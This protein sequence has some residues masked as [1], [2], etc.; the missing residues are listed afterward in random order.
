MTS[1]RTILAR[2]NSLYRRESGISVRTIRPAT[3]RH[4]RATAAAFATDRSNTGLHQLDGIILIRQI[5]GHAHCDS[6]PA[7]IDRYQRG[8]TAGHFLLGFIN[9][10]AQFL[11]I[12][13]VYNLPTK[14]NIADRFHYRFGRAAAFAG[15]RQ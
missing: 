12:E 14:L 6:G 3:L 1:C 15:Q 7:I 9:Q 4:V 10:S 5:I 8:N 13:A 2:K 11:G